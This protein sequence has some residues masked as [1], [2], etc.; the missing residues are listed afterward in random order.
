MIPDITSKTV[1]IPAAFFF[2]LKGRVPVL[3]YAITVTFAMKTLKNTT[4]SPADVLVP[5]FLFSFI[6]DPFLFILL[7]AFIKSL[8]PQL[9]Q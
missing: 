2:A 1:L 6:D 3:V 7:C 8:F 9:Y 5:V 4:H